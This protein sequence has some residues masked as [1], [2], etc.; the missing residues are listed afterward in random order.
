MK[1]FKVAD[2][3]VQVIL[4]GGALLV[5]LTAPSSFS[6]S[7]FMSYVLVGGWQIISLIVHFFYPA[8]YKVGLRKVYS[9]LLAVTAVVFGISIFTGNALDVLAGLL[10]WSPVLAILY[11]I[12][13]LLELKKFNTSLS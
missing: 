6:E 13:C 12:T 7:F 9:V 11:M 3:I 5:N 4:I 10:F 2:C 8:E 1:T